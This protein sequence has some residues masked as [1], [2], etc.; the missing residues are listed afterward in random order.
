[1]GIGNF[2]SSDPGYKLQVNGTGYFGG[3]LS[4]AAY[5]LIGGSYGD[6]AYASVNSTRLMF[7]GGDSDAVTNYYIGTNKEDYGGNYTKLDLRWHTGIRMGAQASYGGIRF[8]NNEDL[9]SVLFSIGASDGNVRSH[10]N[11]Y[12][13]ANNSYNLGS[14]GLRWANIYTN[15]LHLSN[16][17]K[18]GGNEIDGTTGDW[19]IQEGEENLYIINHKNGKKFKI[20]LTEIV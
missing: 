7:G 18:E 17:G 15:D 11:L 8:Y 10:T 6:N 12:P 2:S 20:D 14:T 5:V 1:V 3:N 4:T 16:E 13:S 19:T 9:S